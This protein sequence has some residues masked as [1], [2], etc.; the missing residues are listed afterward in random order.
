[1]F[2]RGKTEEGLYIEAS[3]IGG[4][5]SLDDG[6]INKRRIGHFSSGAGGRGSAPTRSYVN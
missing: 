3:G 5:G 4:F 2:A 1:M 6:S